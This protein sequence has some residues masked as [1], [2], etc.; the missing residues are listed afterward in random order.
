MFKEERKRSYQGLGLC[1]IAFLAGLF[2]LN[3]ISVMESPP[4]GNAL[5]I[6]AGWLFMLLSFIGAALIVRYL[7]KLRKRE[8]KRK[9][10]SKVIFLDDE[11]RRRKSGS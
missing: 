8:R 1:V 4:L 3:V 7:F 9:S 11:R 6:I 2:M 10:G 5:Y